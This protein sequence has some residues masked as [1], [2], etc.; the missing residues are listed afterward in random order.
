MRESE[1]DEI[2]MTQ[3]RLEEAARRSMLRRRPELKV[4]EQPAKKPRP[5]SRPALKPHPPPTPPPMH[6]IALRDAPWRQHDAP[7]DD[8]PTDDAPTVDAPTD[9]APLAITD[10]AG[11]D[12]A[13][14]DDAPT[15]VARTLDI[16]HRYWHGLSRKDQMQAQTL[17]YQTLANLA[18]HY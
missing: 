14:A 16:A 7:I 18:K 3:S 17:A 4:L 11:I 15:D 8:T 13:P 1:S 5:S 2:V 10:I 9:D 6:L 12:G